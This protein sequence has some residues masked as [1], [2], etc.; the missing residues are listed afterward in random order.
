MNSHFCNR[1]YMTPALDVKYIKYPE[2]IN[3]QDRT[4]FPYRPVLMEAEVALKYGQV[5]INADRSVTL[6]NPDIADEPFTVPPHQIFSTIYQTYE[7]LNRVVSTAVRHYGDQ[8]LPPDNELGAET[9][10][11]FVHEEY[12]KFMERML[13]SEADGQLLF[14]YGNFLFDPLDRRLYH[15][16]P[17]QIHE[18][19]LLTSQTLYEDPQGRD[20]Y[21][22]W[23]TL[24]SKMIVICG[25][26]VGSNIADALVKATI[27]ARLRLVDMD[28]TEPGNIFRIARSNL[29]ALTHPLSVNESGSLFEQN[30]RN[31][32]ATLAREL[33]LVNPYLQLELYLDGLSE[34]NV[35][36]VFGEADLIFDEIDNVDFKISLLRMKARD[37]GIPVMMI[38]DLDGRVAVE[39]N[40][41]NHECNPFQNGIS[42]KN[43][44][45]QQIA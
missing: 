38:T 29:A 30:Y 40:P 32:A 27:G 3:Q 1:S 42:E 19:A 10:G 24:K 26:S 33:L 25:N 31:K 17:Q 7:N 8:I 34:R 41:Y 39:Y 9:F 45:H 6:H 21:D 28:F 18:L 14:G 4:Q 13:Q 36:S 22:I 16:A 15:I 35:E 23:R 11:K 2:T 44:E 37:M 43:K 12:T 20:L 5:V